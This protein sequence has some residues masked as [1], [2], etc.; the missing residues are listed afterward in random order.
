MEENMEF[1][2]FPGIMLISAN[3]ISLYNNINAYHAV[4][5]VCYLIVFVPELKYYLLNTI[6][7]AINLIINRNVLC[8][9]E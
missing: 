3:D 1:P 5:L 6:N 2:P 4:N 9:G 8:I 7:D